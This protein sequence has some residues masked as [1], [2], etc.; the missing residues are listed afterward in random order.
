MKQI[1]FRVLSFLVGMIVEWIILELVSNFLP[2]LVVPIIVIQIIVLSSVLAFS[3]I[4]VK[5][6]EIE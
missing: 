2:F 3:Y 5:E 1:M 4:L 6:G